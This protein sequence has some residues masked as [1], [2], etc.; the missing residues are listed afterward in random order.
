MT[1][2]AITVTATDTAIAIVAVTATAAAAA[3]IAATLAALPKAPFEQG[4][5]QPTG[6]KHEQQP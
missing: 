4:T 5:T 3:T 2:T 6:A 1:T